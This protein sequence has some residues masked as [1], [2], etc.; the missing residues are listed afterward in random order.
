MGRSSVFSA[1]QEPRKRKVCNNKLGSIDYTPHYYNL[2][3]SPT[4]SDSQIRKAHRNLALLAHPDK[5]RSQKEKAQEV[6]KILNA[7]ADTLY[8]KKAYS[9]ST[10]DGQFYHENFLWDEKRLLIEPSRKRPWFRDYD[11]RRGEDQSQDP[12]R[13]EA[14]VEFSHWLVSKLASEPARERFWTSIDAMREPQIDSD[15]VVLNFYDCNPVPVSITVKASSKLLPGADFKSDDFDMILVE[16]I[17]ALWVVAGALIS[18]FLLLV[19]FTCC[20]FG[21]R[22]RNR[23]A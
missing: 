22:R 20:C 4:A 16:N 3:V 2:R 19:V 23:G 12:H 5:N 10:Y 1:T 11:Q 17:L 7:A 15:L 13:E 6:I 18:C 8:K 21:R 14:W 9:K